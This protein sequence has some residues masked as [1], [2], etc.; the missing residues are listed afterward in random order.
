MVEK[1][2]MF[3]KKMNYRN[4]VRFSDFF[5]QLA[6]YDRMTTEE[7]LAYFGHIY[8]MSEDEIEKRSALLIDFLEIPSSPSG[9]VAL[10]YP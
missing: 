1:M 4:F 3:S 7:T 10:R 5:Q 8:D 9:T 6:L 2:E